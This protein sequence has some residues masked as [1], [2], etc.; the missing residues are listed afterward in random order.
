MR[1]WQS[2][3]V[4]PGLLASAGLWEAPEGAQPCGVLGQGRETRLSAGRQPACWAEISLCQWGREG[5]GTQGQGQ[6]WGDQ[7]AWAPPSVSG[8][9]RWDRRGHVGM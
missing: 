6:L 7:D 4:T 5:G 9:L 3:E 2:W 8:T 1:Q